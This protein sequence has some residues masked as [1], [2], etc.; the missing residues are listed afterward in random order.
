MLFHYTY[1]SNFSQIWADKKL[2]P[3]PFIVATTKFPK[4]AKD[5]KRLSPVVQLSSNPIME[6][7]MKIN[8]ITHA[9]YFGENSF[10]RIEI[11]DRTDFLSITQYA[12]RFNYSEK[13]FKWLLITGKLAGADIAGWRFSTDPITID[14]SMVVQCHL[15]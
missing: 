14:G 7:T 12:Q 13:K 8:I 10:F 9:R 2:V 6:P 5:F 3:Q 11:P 1:E 4:S 15:Q